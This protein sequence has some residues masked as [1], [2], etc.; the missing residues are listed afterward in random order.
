MIHNAETNTVVFR[1]HRVPVRCWRCWR[2]FDFF[3]P[4][5]FEDVAVYRCEKCPEVRAT[6]I[7]GAG[8][9]YAKAK[10]LDVHHPKSSGWGGKSEDREFLRVFENDWTEPCTCGGRFR[11]RTPV[12]CPHCHAPEIR[13][14]RGHL[15]VVD[16]P[17]IPVLKFSVPLEYAKAAPRPPQHPEPEVIQRPGS[18][19]NHPER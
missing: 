13:L 8:E 2:G 6:E 1:A 18:P 17:P 14:L 9:G 11:L 12:R 7:Y 3:T 10:Y 5:E 16:S 19:P 15:E 4:N